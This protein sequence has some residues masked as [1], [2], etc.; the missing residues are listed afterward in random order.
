M[1]SFITE[2]VHRLSEM[3]RY[4]LSSV[5]HMRKD[6]KAN[7]SYNNKLEVEINRTAHA[8]RDI[9]QLEQLKGLVLTKLSLIDEVIK[10]KRRYNKNLATSADQDFDS[11]R[12]TLDEMRGQINRVQHEN[13]ELLEK[14][15]TDSLTGALN[16]FT[17]ENQLA[18]EMNRYRRYKRT[19]SLIMFDVDHFKDVN[20]TYGH[21]VGDKCLRET[22]RSVRSM[23][24]QNDLLARYGGD[25][26]VILLPETGK[27][28]GLEVAEKI[29]QAIDLTDF[30]IK[31]RKIPL[32]ITLGVTEV[33]P[34]DE[35]VETL[36]SRVD[37]AL[38]QAKR[39]GRNCVVS[40]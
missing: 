4:I 13:K 33:L 3:E 40:I 36:F 31:G 1:A 39:T 37:Q 5:E 9:N 30:T 17:Y 8:V 38:Y 35:H 20:D 24:R 14:L 12:H 7:E 27:E 11:F 28:K 21:I 32:T 34:S 16:R 15:R 10:K 6:R 26:F 23:L 18:E 2:V 19:F 25:E 29:R 22:T